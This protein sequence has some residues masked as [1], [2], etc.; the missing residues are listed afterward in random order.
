MKYLKMRKKRTIL[1]NIEKNDI[2]L[3]IKRVIKFNKDI[4]IFK[5]NYNE[6]SKTLT[7][8]A[9]KRVQIKRNIN[10]T[11]TSF[12]T[13]KDLKIEIDRLQNQ[14]TILDEENINLENIKLLYNSIINKLYDEKENIEKNINDKIQYL[15]GNNYDINIYNYNRINN[16]IEIGISENINKRKYKHITVTEDNNNISV[17]NSKEKDIE[18]ILNLL[19]DDL[20]KLFNNYKR[21]IFF[22]QEYVDKL[23]CVNANFY[24]SITLYSITLTSKYC[25]NIHFEIKY[26]TY[27]N[28]YQVNTDNQ[29]I[30]NYLNEIAPILLNLIYIPIVECPTWT[31]DKLY[32]IRDMELNNVKVYKIKRYSK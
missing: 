17:I 26:N 19:N 2:Q 27:E 29:D 10:K 7:I 28:N 9:N 32:N 16:T 5:I 11:I 8:I 23:R 25:D 6:I 18:K 4:E 15:C 22:E 14:E 30:K 21:Y 13:F 3:I 24:V 31:Q 20:K 1:R 12:K